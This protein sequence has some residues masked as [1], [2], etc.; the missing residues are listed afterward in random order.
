[1]RLGGDV[2]VT[3]G[4]INWAIVGLFAGLVASGI[5]DK[6]GQGFPLNITLGIVGAVVGGFLSDLFSA[7]GATALSVWSTIMA[8]V[9]SRSLCC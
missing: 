5:V 7:S 6:Q 2:A 9:S 8:I 4:I 1:M 3:G